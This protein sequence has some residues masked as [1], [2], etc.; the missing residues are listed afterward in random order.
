LMRL[1]KRVRIKGAFAV[2]SL[3]LIVALS[4]PRIGGSAHLWLNGLYESACVIIIFPAIVAIGAGATLT[5]G[6]SRRTAKFLGGLSYPLYI[7]HYPLIYIYTNWV[8]SSKPSFAQS[9]GAGAMVL[10][11]SL[12]IAYLCLKFYDEP[13]RSWLSRKFLAANVSKPPVGA[14]VAND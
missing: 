2:S 9:V 5:E 14:A 4:L 1:G 8:M 11:G 7:T 6:L 12:T 13:V 3:L 10:A